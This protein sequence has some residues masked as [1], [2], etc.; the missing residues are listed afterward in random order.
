[1]KTEEDVDPDDDVDE[2]D[3]D[4]VFEPVPDSPKKLIM[5]SPA[6]KRRTQSLSALKDKEKATK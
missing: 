1:F 4:D 6:A 5:R 3:D 2:D